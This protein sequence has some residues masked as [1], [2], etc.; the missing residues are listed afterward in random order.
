[1]ANIF[2]FAS[3][4]GSVIWV[5]LSEIFPNRVRSKGQ[6][7]GSS[8]HWVMNAFISG[9]FPIMSQKS[10]GYPFVFFAVMMALQFFVVLFW[11][12]ETKGVSLEQLQKQ[13][14]IA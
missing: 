10:G 8:A 3:S 4:Q 6:G 1:V 14:N 9:I 11:F 5:Y 12:P 2:F 13:L 7:L